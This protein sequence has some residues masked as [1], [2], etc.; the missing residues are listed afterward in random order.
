MSDWYE[1]KTYID[2]EINPLYAHKHPDTIVPR[3]QIPMGIMCR[4]PIECN[5]VQM[6]QDLL[7]FLLR[8]LSVELM[9]PIHFREI[10]LSSLC[11]SYP[12][13]ESTIIRY[14]QWLIEMSL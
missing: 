5:T 11:I 12:Q 4:F 14:K 9:V 7:E 10:A 1:C 3:H 8:L 6:T 13:H 2:Q